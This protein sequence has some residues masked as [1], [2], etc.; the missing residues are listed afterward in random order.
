MSPHNQQIFAREHVAPSYARNLWRFVQRS[1]TGTPPPPPA[2]SSCARH[3]HRLDTPAVRAGARAHR[4]GMA[5]KPAPTPPGRPCCDPM[6]AA[7]G[8]V[9]IDVPGYAKCPAKYRLDAAEM[10]PASRHGSVPIAKQGSRRPRSSSPDPFRTGSANGHAAWRR[11]GSRSGSPKLDRATEVTWSRLGQLA[12]P[13][14][15]RCSD[16]SAPVPALAEADG[17]VTTY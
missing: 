6:P 10:A 15:M 12:E 4:H 2:G 1:P 16:R 13:G 7:D 17:P 9:P 11:A 5:A 14:V 3:R 8:S